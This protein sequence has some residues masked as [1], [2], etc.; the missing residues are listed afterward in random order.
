MKP[1]KKNNT[2]K[3]GHFK[4][5]QNIPK[6]TGDPFFR[7]ARVKKSEKSACSSNP[8]TPAVFILSVETT[9]G[10]ADHRKSIEL[11]SM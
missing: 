6:D 3:S 7:I 11:K 2:L 4:Q 5:L 8:R 1:F 10:R 9:A